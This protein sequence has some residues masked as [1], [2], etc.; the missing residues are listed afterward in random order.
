MLCVY[1]RSSLLMTFCKA[2]AG[3]IVELKSGLSTGPSVVTIVYKIIGCSIHS[4][5]LIFCI[6]VSYICVT[7]TGSITWNSNWCW[8]LPIS[9]VCNKMV[10]YLEVNNGKFPALL[11]ICIIISL[12]R[13]LAHTTALEVYLTT[14]LAGHLAHLYCIMNHCVI[15]I[16]S[17]NNSIFTLL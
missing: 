4:N 11:L 14:R 7:L 5:P 15:K 10:E 6:T 13:P 2:K 8:P 16:L 9:L 17:V 12:T 3:I 1:E